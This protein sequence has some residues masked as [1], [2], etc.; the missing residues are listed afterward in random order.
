[1][2]QKIID[3]LGWSDNHWTYKFCNH[4]LNDDQKES[5]ITSCLVNSLSLLLSIK[6]IRKFEFFRDFY[7]EYIIKVKTHT[8][9]F[10]MAC[11]EYSE[12]HCNPEKYGVLYK[13]RKFLSEWKLLELPEDVWKIIDSAKTKKEKK[14][15]LLK[16]MKIKAF[17]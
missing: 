11:D 4:F 6:P 13:S 5:F 8:H 16:V 10:M 2:E 1:M 17:W 3:V 14:A 15:A 9:I 12:L 7:G